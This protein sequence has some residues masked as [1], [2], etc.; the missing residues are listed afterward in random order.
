MSE[1][2]MNEYY[3]VNG[4]KY[5]T[6]PEIYDS[7]CTGCI[8]NVGSNLCE[9][10]SDFTSCSGIIFTDKKPNKTEQQDSN[11]EILE[12]FCKLR[13]SLKYYLHGAKY[14]TALKAFTF[15]QSLAV[16][17]RKD[18]IT[19]EFQHQ[20]EIALYITTLKGIIDEERAITVALLHD[21]RED[22]DIEM[23]YLID[24]FGMD[25]ANDVELLTKKFKGIEKTKEQYFAKLL[26]SVYA[27]LVKGVDR[28]HNVQSMQNVFTDEKKQQYLQ[29]V[30]QYFQPMLKESSK[31]YPNQFLAFM[32]IRTM[33]KYQYDLISYSLK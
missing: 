27:A 17:T 29:E 30:T 22:Y 4:K 3:E 13:I 18:G 15:V 16:G 8:A 25:I 23:E 6:I 9:L 31:I 24:N 14:H 19:P 1:F 2:V 11:S 26:S 7:R 21:V 33:L 32:N 5:Y 20:I 12:R 28:I 10:L